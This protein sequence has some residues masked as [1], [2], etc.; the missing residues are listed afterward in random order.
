MLSVM[1]GSSC[2]RSSVGVS[3]RTGPLPTAMVRPRSRRQ[4]W[5][6]S[7]RRG[8]RAGRK[9]GGGTHCCARGSEAPPASAKRAA[10]HGSEAGTSAA[11]IPPAGDARAGLTL[12]AEAAAPSSCCSG[13]SNCPAHC[14][15]TCSL[16]R[17]RSCASEPLPGTA[18]VTWR[19]SAA[20]HATSHLAVPALL[21]LLGHLVAPPPRTRSATWQHVPLQQVR[22][23]V[24]LGTPKKAA[25]RPALPA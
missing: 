7:A 9:P 24:C 13:C 20:A 17:G 21:L 6:S 4:W 5:S 25:A 18:P 8:D 14:S 15:L 1:D 22:R 19:C 2:S 10:S 11:A 23:G 3:K 12:G 16:T